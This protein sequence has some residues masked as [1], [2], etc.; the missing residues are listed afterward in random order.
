MTKLPKTGDRIPTERFHVSEMNVNYGE[1]FGQDE[2]DKNLIGQLR[3]GRIVQK[4]T[5]R[6]EGD[7][8][9]VVIG[10]RRFLGK[11]WVGAK[12]FVVGKDCVIEEMTDEEARE[13][14]WIENLDIL[15][16]GMNPVR[17]ARQ[18]SEILA[19]STSGLRGMAR[20]WDISAST[21]SEWLKILE[22]SPKM[23]NALAE[24]KVFFKEALTVARAKLGKELQDE[25]ADLLETEGLDAF[26]RELSRILAKKGKRGIP[27]G[28]Y[29]V[30]RVTWDKRNVKE[31]EPYEIVHEVAE[32]KGMKPPEYIKDFIIRH[33]DEIKREK[34]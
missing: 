25:L 31:M 1:P 2:R 33:I 9:G 3:R 16:K 22:L 34:P 30:D 13:A 8:Y 20:R 18:L 32:A 24:G 11:K 21:L 17:R 14:S 4:F 28:V 23:Q 12:E 6:P 29:E 15:R 10:R 27:R 5:A 19:F 7:E 26:K